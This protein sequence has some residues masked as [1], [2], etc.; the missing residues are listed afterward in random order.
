M[1]DL[2][3]DH[4]SGGI[5]QA[6]SVRA[7]DQSLELLLDSA[8]PM[9][10]SVREAGAFRL[11][12]LGPAERVLVQGIYP[13]DVA[14]EEHDIFIVPIAREASGMRYEAIFY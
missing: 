3:I 4:F 14:G 5:G 7:G 10:R 2:S 1:G 11:E 13:F 9:S 12:F 8:E 6:F